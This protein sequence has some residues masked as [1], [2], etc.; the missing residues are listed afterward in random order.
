MATLISDTLSSRADDP[1]RLL[2]DEIGFGVTDSLEERLLEYLLSLDL[3]VRSFRFFIL[4][5]K[6]D[7]R[8]D[9]SSDDSTSGPVEFSSEL[10]TVDEEDLLER[11]DA[12]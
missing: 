4:D 7:C 11:E 3:F 12:L 10:P 1:S 5:S 6:C 8:E 9:P 2:N